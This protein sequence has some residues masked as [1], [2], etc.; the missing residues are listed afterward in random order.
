MADPLSIAGLA[1]AVVQVAT[2]VYDYVGSVKNAKEDIRRLSQ[3]MFALKGTL[4]HMVAFHKSGGDDNHGPQMNAVIKLTAET[5]ETIKKRLERRSTGLGRSVHVITWPFQKSDIDKLVAALERAK[6]WFM[7]T[8]MQDTTEQTRA[9]FS[10][11]QHLTN[12]I[13]EDILSR[14]LDRMTQDVE[15]TIRGLS[16]VDPWEDHMRVSRDL[17]PGTGQWFMDKKFEE[18]A[19]DQ[20][21]SR[22]L[23]WVKGK[24]GAGKSSLFSSVVDELKRRCSPQPKQLVC[25][26][27]Y[28]HSGNAATQV[29]VNVFGS[30]L[31]QLCEI[32]PEMAS[33]IRPL[34]RP[35]N[36]LIAQ[37]LLSISDLARLLTSA[38][39]SIERCYMLVDAL[40]ETPHYRLI[41]SLL[42]KLSQI[43]PSLRVLV[44]S[45]SN[46]PIKGK[47][48]LLRQMGE[49]A[50]D[51][52]I[53]VYVEHRL[54]TESSFGNLSERIKMEIKTTMTT[55]A[56]GM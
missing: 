41:V 19:G 22:P 52:D 28:C 31:A 18:W 7:M 38:L 32:R 21:T 13:H 11:V 39:E 49:S 17:V 47:Q 56:H 44:T 5:L 6:T 33:E 26:F 24:S 43:C 25:C 35:G 16:P 10:E 50:V 54:T 37:T 3:E 23:L 34:L 14:Q 9:V 48:I 4:D 15:V 40:N 46:P 53:G 1:F 30:L 45:T 27:F 12:I 20:L 36:R 42:S 2:S 55:L 51:H 8:L 29:P